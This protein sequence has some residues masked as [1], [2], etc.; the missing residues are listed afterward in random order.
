MLLVNN[1]PITTGKFPNN[2]TYV[3]FDELKE[4]DPEKTH[5]I[6]MRFESND[7]LILL[8]LLKRSMDDMGFRHVTLCCPYLPYSALD[9]TEGKRCLGVKY[10]GSLINSLNFD[11]V[12]V[13]EAHS[14]VALAVVDRIKNTNYSEEIVEKAAQ[15]LINSG[16][17]QNS[18]LLVFPDS[19]AE[20]RYKALKNKFSQW[21]SFQKKRRFADGKLD[22][23]ILSDQQ[24][25]GD[26]VT[27]ALIVDDLCRG[28]RT[29][30]LVAQ[31]V[32]EKF[33][34][35]TSC[36]LCVTHTEESV[37]TGPILSDKHITAILTTDSCIQKITN[38]KL[39][40]VTKW[41]GVCK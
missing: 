14:D 24:L 18:I 29:A 36:F 37:Y 27:T 16:V 28:G 3:D 4:L 21:V 30:C 11:S 33:P 35:I 15:R 13:L 26:Q 38:K 6:S 19:G 9:R 20:K 22:R 5:E 8:L 32:S 25:S 1:K 41:G 7:D 17:N 10:I 12:S 23:P 39:I 40:D 34:T 31:E 2:E